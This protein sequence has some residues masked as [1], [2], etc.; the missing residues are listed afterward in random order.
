L[1][2]LVPVV[3]FFLNMRP[4]HR[5]LAAEKKRELAVVQRNILLACR[6]LMARIDAQEGTGTLGAEINA[7]VVYEERLRAASTWPYDT[8]MLRT[9]F[10]SVIVPGIAALVRVIAEIMFF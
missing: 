6:A 10:F 2:M 5:V 1:L 4:T 7:L 3:V 9:L 8:A